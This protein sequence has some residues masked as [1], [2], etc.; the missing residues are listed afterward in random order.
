MGGQILLD[1]NK[2]PFSRHKLLVF[3]GENNLL[4]LRLTLYHFIAAL[5]KGRVSLNT[6]GDNHLSAG[7]GR[8][9]FQS[10]GANRK[11]Q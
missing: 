11:A 10:L 2:F 8:N 9:S 1:I 6:G 3:S 7:G 5:V 4:D